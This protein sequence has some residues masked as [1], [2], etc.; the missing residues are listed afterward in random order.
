MLTAGWPGGHGCCTRAGVTFACAIVTALALSACS[1]VPDPVPQQS[2]LM[3]MVSTASVATPL[4]IEVPMPVLVRPPTALATTQGARHN[5]IVKFGRPYQVAGS[6][7]YPAQGSGYDEE[8]LASWY[9]P[10][11]QGKPTANGETYNMNRLTAA[12]PTLPMPCYVSVTNT[13]NGRMIVVRINDRGPYK[14]GRIIDLSHRA[15]ELLGVTHSGTA[16][17][18]VRYLRMAPLLADERFEEQFLNRQPWYH[19]SQLAS[20]EARPVGTHLR[21]T[22]QNAD[23]QSAVLS[24]Q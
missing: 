23:W 7:Y 9:G 12:N 17:V 24:G 18:R 8:G 5:A 20:A 11:F 6:W 4:E 16:N 1:G 14:T 10:E 19:G 21:P 2:Q 3:P 13:S 22:L 15:A